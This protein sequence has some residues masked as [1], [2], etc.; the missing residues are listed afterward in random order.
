MPLNT[1]QPVIILISDQVPFLLDEGSE[2]GTE[3]PEKSSP[4]AALDAVAFPAHP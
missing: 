1:I 2:P 3:A 4:H